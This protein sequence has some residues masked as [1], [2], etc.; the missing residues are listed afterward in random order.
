M[1]S[2]VTTS[3]PSRRRPRVVDAAL[4]IDLVISDAD[5]P[6]EILKAIYDW[7]HERV[8]T[9]AR[10]VA[11]FGAGILATLIVSLI[12]HAPDASIDIQLASY[13]ALFCFLTIGMGAAMLRD[14][15][16]VE[17]EYGAAQAALARLQPLR[18]FFLSNGWV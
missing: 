11:G 12:V 17:Q 18:S 5:D 16:R 2:A 8:V 9:Q 3:T 15:A 14:A 4:L 13:T 6:A 1:T 10:A 7:Q